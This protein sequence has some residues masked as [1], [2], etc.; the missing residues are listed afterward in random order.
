[1][2]EFDWTINWSSLKRYHRPG[3]HQL[4]VFVNEQE[5]TH[6]RRCVTGDDGICVAFELDEEGKPQVSPLGGFKE[7]ILYGKVEVTERPRPPLAEVVP[8]IEEAVQSE[9]LSEE[10]E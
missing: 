1:M 9:P 6:V 8:D 7:R 4:L 2:A 3:D 5:V 10:T